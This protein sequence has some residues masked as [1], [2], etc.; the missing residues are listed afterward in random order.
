MS[1]ME[2]RRLKI[3]L[4]E[5]QE[6]FEF[7]SYE[8]Q[9]YLDRETGEVVLLSE[10]ESSLLEAFLEES[11]S[12]EPTSD[13]LSQWLSATDVP[14]LQ[15]TAVLAAFEVEAGFGERFVEVPQVS[16][17]EGYRDMEDYIDTVDD[18]A[19]RK[20]LSVAIDGRGAFRRFKDVLLDYPEER[21][22]WFTFKD[23]RMRERML[24]W[25]EDEGIELVDAPN[26]PS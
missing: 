1:A 4:A 7:Q 24:D 26:P 15:H 18:L 19:L 25:L 11:T 9:Y 17:H 12:E 3:D 23:A 14:E 20:L 13:E 6:A 16:S 8:M 10:E 22:R 21:Q 2:K 5:L